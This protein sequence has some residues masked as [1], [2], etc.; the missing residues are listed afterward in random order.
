MKK[1]HHIQSSRSVTFLHIRI[2]IDISQEWPGARP[3]HITV[4][5]KCT[6]RILVTPARACEKL[7]SLVCGKHAHWG[8]VLYQVK[9][10]HVE[11]F[12]DWKLREKSVL[13]N[14]R[15]T[16]L[17]PIKNVEAL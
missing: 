17:E 16:F 15:L 9:T 6:I 2:V 12:V 11:M 5:S 13:R 7:G 1:R 4:A 8:F 3:F 14:I 10:R